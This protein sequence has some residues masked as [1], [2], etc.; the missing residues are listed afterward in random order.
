MASNP[1]PRQAG[2]IPK[3]TSS[4]FKPVP[5]MWNSSPRQSQRSVLRSIGKQNSTRYQ[6]FK[7]Q[8]KWLVV[9]AAETAT[10]NYIYT[11]HLRLLERDDRAYRNNLQLLTNKQYP[12]KINRIA[13]KQPDETHTIETITSS[14][15]YHTV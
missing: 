6:C 13:R 11:L 10:N 15:R 4:D 7:F 5:C 14:S 8:G 1:Y 9:G 2:E 12:S 3:L